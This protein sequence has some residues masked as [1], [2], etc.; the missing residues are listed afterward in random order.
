MSQLSNRLEQQIN[1][2]R[3]SWNTS[4]HDV[5]QSRMTKETSLALTYFREGSH[6]WNIFEIVYSHAGASPNTTPVSISTARD[7]RTPSWLSE[8]SP[9]SQSSHQWLPMVTF[10]HKWFVSS[11]YPQTYLLQVDSQSISHTPTGNEAIWALQMCW[12]HVTVHLLSTFILRVWLR[13]FIENC[14]LVLL[15]NNTPRL[16]TITVSL[17]IGS[18]VSVSLGFACSFIWPLLLFAM[19][20]RVDKTTMCIHH[21]A[22]YAFN[23][24]R[25]HVL[26]PISTP[27]CKHDITDMYCWKLKPQTMRTYSSLTTS[28]FGVQIKIFMLHKHV[29]NTIHKQWTR[30]GRKFI[31]Q[32]FTNTN[33]KWQLLLQCHWGQLSH[34][35]TTMLC[36]IPQK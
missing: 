1:Q 32:H 3:L 7:K 15:Q 34:K 17:T 9:L 25:T 23:P 19:H 31:I 10:L 8:T 4:S 24:S 18:K 22:L 20:Y 35:I 13:A 6:S 26:I 14:V 27:K 28:T 29:P 16:F 36:S 30:T 11:L 2:I 33:F 21:L 5:I 12:H